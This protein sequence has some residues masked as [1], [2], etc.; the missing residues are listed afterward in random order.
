[1]SVADYFVHQPEDTTPIQCGRE[2]A[3]RQFDQSIALIVAVG[4]IAGGLLALRSFVVPVRSQTGLTVAAASNRPGE[5]GRS[6]FGSLPMR[7]APE[8]SSRP[9]PQSAPI[10][11][12]QTRLIAGK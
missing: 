5:Y 7:L 1:M 3:R 10:D 8:P 2:T 11:P 6:P 9:T 12:L 4:A